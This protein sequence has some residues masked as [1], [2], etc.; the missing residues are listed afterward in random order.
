MINA[1]DIIPYVARERIDD[2][3]HISWNGYSRINIGL[4]R[5][6]NLNEDMER[7]LNVAKYEN[8]YDSHFMFDI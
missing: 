7:F 1:K 5:Q 8:M 6:G 4:L 2:K 3:L